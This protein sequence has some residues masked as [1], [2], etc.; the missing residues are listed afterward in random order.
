[1][2]S[3]ALTTSD[4]TALRKMGGGRGSF[5]IPGPAVRRMN[6]ARIRRRGL[7]FQAFGHLACSSPYKILLDPASSGDIHL[8]PTI[9]LVQDIN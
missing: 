5:G 6:R 3:G 9:S 4:A 1:M 8:I 2:I 7:V